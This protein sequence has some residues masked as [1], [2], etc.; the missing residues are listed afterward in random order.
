MIQSRLEGDFV[1]YEQFD[2]GTNQWTVISRS[3]R[4]R[5]VEKLMAPILE[6]IA[7]GEDISE[8]EM[9][10]LQVGR[11]LSLQNAFLLEG[12]QGS[13]GDLR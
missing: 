10:A 1:V 7:K 13:I 6:K 5:G 11:S 3:P 4:T 12:S 8:G 2:R 9:R